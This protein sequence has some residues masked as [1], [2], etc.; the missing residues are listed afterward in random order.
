M[1]LNGLHVLIVVWQAHVVVLELVEA[2]HHVGAASVDL[3]VLALVGYA[4]VDVLLLI[5]L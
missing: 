4:V 3:G 5:L 1:V 2:V